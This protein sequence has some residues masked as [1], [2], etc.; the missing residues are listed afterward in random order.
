VRC[1]VEET[2]T[3][4]LAQ[5]HVREIGHYISLVTERNLRMYAA[6]NERLPSAAYEVVRR[7]KSL[8]YLPY[9]DTYEIR[10][11]AITI[12]VDAEL[13]VISY[14]K[15]PK[16]P[17]LGEKQG[18]QEMITYQGD[19]SDFMEKIEKEIG[20]L[21]RYEKRDYGSFLSIAISSADDR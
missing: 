12:K 1:L 20:K 9:G 7:L 8:P 14:P 18:E 17:K 21:K 6:W 4:N 13:V 11:M 19:L 5:N 15:K 2:V 10:D 16:K 3:A